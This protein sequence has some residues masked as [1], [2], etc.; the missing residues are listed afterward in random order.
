MSGDPKYDII[1]RPGD[2]IKV[3][4]DITGEFEITGE[5]NF[6]GFISLI[7]RKMTLKMAIAA[8]GGLSDKAWPGRVEVI[9]RIG[10]NKEIIV[11]VDLKKIASG[12]QPDF[13]IKPNDVINVGSHPMARYLSVIRN[14]FRS[15]YGFGFIY[16][17]NFAF[18]QG[19][20]QRIPEIDGP[21]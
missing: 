4:V 5:V 20:Q 13:F 12:Q 7:G 11:M 18:D 17:R 6:N 3:P 19:N 2:S 14:G 9:R 15:T 21:F 1:I 8:A 16:D 10:E